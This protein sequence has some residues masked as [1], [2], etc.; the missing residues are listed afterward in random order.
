MQLNFH[1]FFH[2]PKNSSKLKGTCSDTRYQEHKGSF[3]CFYDYNTL[4][5]TTFSGLKYVRTQRYSNW[6]KSARKWR[7]YTTAYNSNTPKIFLSKTQKVHHFLLGSLLCHPGCCAHHLFWIL[8]W[9]C[10]PQSLCFQCLGNAGG[11]GWMQIQ[12]GKDTK[13]QIF[14]IFIAKFTKFIKLRIHQIN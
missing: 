13:M 4:P 3:E 1:D 7:I 5:F 11:S 12:K 8:S 2:L 9:H 14:L 10:Q 6:R